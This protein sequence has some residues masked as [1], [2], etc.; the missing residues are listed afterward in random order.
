MGL[1][2]LARL[3]AIGFP[4]PSLAYLMVW[5]A[6]GYLDR[7]WLTLTLFLNIFSVCDINSNDESLTWRRKA[8]QILCSDTRLGYL[9]QRLYLFEYLKFYLKKTINWSLLINAFLIIDFLRQQTL[10]AVSTSSVCRR[11]KLNRWLKSKLKAKGPL[12][13]RRVTLIYAKSEDS[14][15][16]YVY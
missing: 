16:S 3:Y 13:T 12:I 1:G 6:C 15:P 14:T 5:A 2:T 4:Y 7:F 10:I 8:S 9:L 11:Y